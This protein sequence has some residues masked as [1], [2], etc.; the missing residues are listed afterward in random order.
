LFCFPHG[1]FLL[2]TE[3]LYL[4]VDFISCH[5]FIRSKSF[6][7]ESLESFKYRFL[8]SAN[9]NNLTSFFPICIPLFLSCFI[10]MAKI[11]RTILNKSSESGHPY[12]F[13]CFKRNAFSL[14]SLSMMLTIGF[15]YI[16]FV[17]LWYD[18][19]TP[20]LLKGCWICQNIF[21]IYWDDHGIFVL[22]SIYV[23]YYI[24]WFAYVDPFLHP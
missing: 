12:L 11:L 13:F 23:L 4:N 7:L 18:L 19:S 3:V 17:M 10:A 5:L 2:Y 22:D 1:S 16:T 9:M 15:I 21:C 8:W 6:L 24:Y 20:N 14:F